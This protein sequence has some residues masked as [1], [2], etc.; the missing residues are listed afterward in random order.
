MLSH[1]NVCQKKAGHALTCFYQ[2]MSNKK[3]KKKHF[4]KKNINMENVLFD[5]VYR[6]SVNKR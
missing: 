4:Q 5:F 2:S 3:I 1:P 6:V